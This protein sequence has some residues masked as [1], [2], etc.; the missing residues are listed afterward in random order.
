MYIFNDI[1]FK[2][3]IFLLSLESSFSTFEMWFFIGQRKCVESV[4]K[5]LKDTLKFSAK[6]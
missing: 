3:Y 5:C 1:H 4:L 2:P 6:V